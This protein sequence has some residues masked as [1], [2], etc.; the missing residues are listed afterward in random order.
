MAGTIA[1]PVRAPQWVLTYQGVNITAN[2]SQMVTSIRY[3]DRLDGASGTLEVALEDH[4]KRWQG[5]WQPVEGDQ[6]NLMIGYSDGPLLPCGDFQIDDLSLSGPPDLFQIG[7]LAAYIT[8]AMRTANSSGYEN[9]TLT[10]IAAT[11]ASK[12]GLTVIA[13]DSSQAPAFARVTQRQETDLAFLKRLAQQHNYEFTIRGKQL[14]FYSRESLESSAP[15]ATISRNDLL[16]FDFRLKTHRIYKASEVSYLLPAAKQLV[17]Q[18]VAETAE[19]PTSDT[20]KLVTRCENGQQ[21]T[22]KATSALH[23]ANMVRA[24]ATFTAVGATVYAA[25]STVTVTDFGFNDG[26]YLIEGARHRLERA[27]GYTTELTMR[28]V[29]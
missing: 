21:A 4:E 8:P 17:T 24:Y 11:I 28:R 12:Y 18:R 14:V 13:A 22:L 5:P 10:Q 20:L 2:I 29:E 1:F 19:T 27:T 23:A 16:R 25:G 26:I 15:V 7:C 3:L 6:V 9:Q